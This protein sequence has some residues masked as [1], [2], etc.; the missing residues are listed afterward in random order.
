LEQLQKENKIL[1]VT[2]RGII[3]LVEEI[4]KNMP[5]DIRKAENS[6]KLM[7]T[8]SKITYYLN[9]RDRRDGTTLPTSN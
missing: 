7:S 4:F 9:E 5:E 6:V 2:L 8:L 1:R 3:V